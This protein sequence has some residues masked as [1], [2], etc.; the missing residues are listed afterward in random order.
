MGGRYL[1]IRGNAQP[2]KRGVIPLVCFVLTHSGTLLNYF[3]EYDIKILSSE[4]KC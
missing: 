3:S 4:E 2:G 1:A